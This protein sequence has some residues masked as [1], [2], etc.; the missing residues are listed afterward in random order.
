MWQLWGE[1][2]PVVWLLIWTI[3]VL[4]VVSG[5]GIFYIHSV[6]YN[7]ADQPCKQPSVSYT[8]NGHLQES[9]L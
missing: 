6:Y 5:G 3:F 2:I 1:Y 4:H 9:F 7:V 8:F